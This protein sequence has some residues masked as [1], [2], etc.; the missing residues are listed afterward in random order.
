MISTIDCPQTISLLLFRL[1]VF[2]WEA[3][4]NTHKTEKT[5]GCTSRLLNCRHIILLTIKHGYLVGSVFCY[6]GP[7]EDTVIQW[8]TSQNIGSYICVQCKITRRPDTIQWFQLLPSEYNIPASFSVL[9]RNMKALIISFIISTFGS[10]GHWDWKTIKYDCELQSLA[11]FRSLRDFVSHAI[12]NLMLLIQA[13][14]TDCLAVGSCHSRIFSDWLLPAKIGS[15]HIQRLR[16]ISMVGINGVA[17]V[18]AKLFFGGNACCAG[19]WKCHQNT[20]VRAIK[21]PTPTCIKTSTLLLASNP[22]G[23]LHTLKRFEF[24]LTRQNY[25][26]SGRADHEHFHTKKHLFFLS[27]LASPGIDFKKSRELW[28]VHFAFR[29]KTVTNICVD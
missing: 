27:V 29:V 6:Y 21:W 17:R 28:E 25:A 19:F 2:M 10:L 22:N 24:C 16:R 8:I 20:G 11:K 9:V 3:E 23:K 12:L 7:E 14:C 5:K 26:Q 4:T 18:P 1:H 15:R 13:K